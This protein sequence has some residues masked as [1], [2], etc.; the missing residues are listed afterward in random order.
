MKK[1]IS[2]MVILLTL[3]SST[4]A[5]EVSA[6]KSFNL[7][8][9]QGAPA[10]SNVYIQYLDG[11]VAKKEGKLSYYCSNYQMPTN[12]AILVNGYDSTNQVSYGADAIT[13]TGF[14]YW[15]NEDFHKGIS[16]NLVVEFGCNEG[17]H[18]IGLYG[19]YASVNGYYK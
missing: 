17:A 13:G 15:L 19:T 10:S 16:Y 9:S 2:M 11:V 5:F 1:R 14:H 7:H 12:T 8:Y 6:Y 3:L 18:G 4:F